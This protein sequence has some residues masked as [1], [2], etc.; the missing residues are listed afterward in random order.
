M[1]DL[2]KVTVQYVDCGDPIESEAR[3]QRVLL[4][5]MEGLVATT[6][7]NMVAAAETQAYQKNE[8]QAV[9]QAEMQS[10][11][12]H[13]DEENIPVTAARKRGRPPLVRKT[14]GKSPLR[15]TG[16][17]SASRKMNLIQKSPR[18][19]KVQ[20]TQTATTGASMSRTMTPRQNANNSNPTGNAAKPPLAPSPNPITRS[21]DF[22]NQPN[23][24]P[25]K[26]Q[27]GTAVVWGTHRQFVDSEIYAPASFQTFSS[28]LRQKNADDIVFNKFEWMGYA[29]HTLVSP[30][31]HGG[32]GLALF[33]KQEIE[34]DMLHTCKNFI[35]T[36]V[37]AEGK[38]FYITFVR[39][40]P[41]TKTKGLE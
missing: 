8:Q 16:S 38:T 21:V 40:G 41:Y 39:V 36:K 37:K 24:L 27:L 11:Q 1:A 31:G 28:S 13:Q 32:G 20:A 17:S 25:E 33:W 18:R 5:E 2:Q 12:M 35:D 6:A 19:R 7:A 26:W 3:W 22:Q 9:I 10:I 23:P 14:L 29:A 15:L 4:S 30:E 34:M